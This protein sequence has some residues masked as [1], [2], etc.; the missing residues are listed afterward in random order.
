MKR[1][2]LIILFLAISTILFPQEKTD[3]GYIVKTGDK[4]PDVKLTLTTG[5]TIRLSDL[6]GKVVVLQFT[7]SWCSVCRKEMPHLEKEVWLP[8][9][10]KDFMLIGVDFDEPLEKVMVFKKQMKIT[11]PMALDPGA[12]IFSLFARKE[13]GVTR[14]VVI[15]QN[16]TIVFLTRLYDRE[17]FEKMVTKINLL[18]EE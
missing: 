5:K 13:S 4:A 3:R 14:N 2:I 18:L 15:D 17:E 10:D 12:E 9:K 6:K 8:N 11:Y 1:N 16:G 7:A